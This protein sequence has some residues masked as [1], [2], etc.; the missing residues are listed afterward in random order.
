MAPARVDYTVGDSTEV[1]EKEYQKDK[2][3]G[4]Y[5]EAFAQSAHT[6][7][8]D[9]EING[10]DTVIPAKYPH[11]LPCKSCIILIFVDMFH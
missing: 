5:K 3:Q 4:I 9:T 10:S 7:N 8:Y 6:T 11:Y 2:K 1:A